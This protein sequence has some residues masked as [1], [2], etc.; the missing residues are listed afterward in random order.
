[1]SFFA[2]NGTQAMGHIAGNGANNVQLLAS[3]DRSLKENIVPYDYRE[4]DLQA[5]I[6][7]PLRTFDWIENSEHKEIGVI[8]DEVALGFSSSVVDMGDNILGVAGGLTDT[9]FLKLIGAIQ[10]LASRVETLE[11]AQQ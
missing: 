4:N 3:S 2:S 8:A 7:L 5:F 6:D 11:S 1:M 10:V 9:I